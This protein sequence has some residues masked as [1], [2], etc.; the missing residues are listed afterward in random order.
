MVEIPGTLG[1]SGQ[2]D[3]NLRGMVYFT[4]SHN[5]NYPERIFLMNS[6]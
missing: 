4:F 5:L 2:C 6:N 1:A 3:L